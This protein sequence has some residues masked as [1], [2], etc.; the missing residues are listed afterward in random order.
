MQYPSLIEEIKVLCLPDKIVVCDGSSEEYQQ[1]TEMMCK[2]G[3]LTKLKREGSFYARTDPSDVARSEESVFICSDHEDDAGPTNHWVAPQEMKKR[4]DLL[5]AGCMKGRT[6]YVIPYSM[7][8][9]GSSMVKYGIEITDSPYV[10]ASMHIMTRM[11]SGVLRE[12]EKGEKFTLGIHSVGMPLEKG[13]KDLH[14]PCNE[15]KVIAHFPK[16]QEVWSFGSGYG[17][18]ALIGKKCFALRIASTMARDEGWMAEH[19]LIMGVT[20][21]QGVKKYFAAAF[22]S[23]CGKTNLAMMRSSLP[24]W[25]VTCVGDDI[26]WMKFDQEGV[27]RAINPENGFFGVAPGTSLSTNPYAMRTVEK[28]TIFTNVALTDDGDVWWERMT[29]EPPHHLTDWKGISWT[30]QAE[31][32]AAHPN[33]RFTTPI[34]QCPILDERA[35]DPEGVPIEGII[36]GGRRSSLLPLVMQAK[37]WRQG[38]FYG[39]GL[40]S[41]TT[42][43][44]KGSVGQL[45]HDPFAMLPFCGYHMADYFSH[46]LGLQKSGRKMPQIFSVNWF[47]KDSAGNFLWPGFGENIRVIK[48]MFERIEGKVEARD[49]PVGFLPL[50][51][52]TEG[53]NLAPGVLEKLLLVNHHGYLGNIEQE[54]EYFALFGDQLPKELLFELEEIEKG[55]T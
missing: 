14:W 27:L 5:F 11:G 16:T 9:P 21:P 4:L 24:G 17:G 52:D 26:A 35:F 47:R 40:T 13:D 2:N 32:P 7:G 20:N 1:I 15:E 41:E 45:R 54:K 30:P 28:N 3:T 12:I 25:E 43:A 42:A 19:M 33:S 31:S 23:A 38:V 36:F 22:P 8:I 48:W 46:W 29:Q 39:A 53:L 34:N 49:E 37:S 18:N 10:V 55:L 50:T 51:L 44:A 6:M